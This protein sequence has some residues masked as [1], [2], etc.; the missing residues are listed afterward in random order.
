MTIS[1]QRKQSGDETLIA[2]SHSGGNILHIRTLYNADDWG[3]CWP[4]VMIANFRTVSLHSK[5]PLNH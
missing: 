2:K 1:F 3:S 5:K 4:N